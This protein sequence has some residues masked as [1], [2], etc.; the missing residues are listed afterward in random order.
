M[1]LGLPLLCQ[2]LLT[3]SQSFVRIRIILFLLLLLKKLLNKHVLLFLLIK[4]LLGVG[5]VDGE[6]SSPTLPLFPSKVTLF[7]CFLYFVH[8]GREGEVLDLAR[9]DALLLFHALYRIIHVNVLLNS[10]LLEIFLELIETVSHF[11]GGLIEFPIQLIFVEVDLAVFKVLLASDIVEA[12]LSVGSPV[13]SALFLPLLHKLLVLAELLP[14]ISSL[15]L[16]NRLDKCALI[17]C[18]IKGTIKELFLGDIKFDEVS[19][20]DFLLVCSDVLPTHSAWLD[21][22][23]HDISL[24]KVLLKLPVDSALFETGHCL[25]LESI[26]RRTLTFLNRKLELVE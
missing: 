9:R 16:L 19:I 20:L 8:R 7:L 1:S 25:G 21:T 17:V 3:L 26:R 22:A 6:L 4:A 15:I 13:L 11:G 10:Q 18:L 12:S 2:H 23:S 5:L 24:I 14:V